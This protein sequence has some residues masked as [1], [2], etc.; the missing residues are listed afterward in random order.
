[1]LAEEK[2]H[3]HAPD[4]AVPRAGAGPVRPAADGVNNQ[5]FSGAADRRTGRRR[6]G[7][8]GPSGGNSWP[9]DQEFCAKGW[10][11][12]P[13]G[14]APSCR[15]TVTDKPELVA[16]R[17]DRGQRARAARAVDRRGREPPLSGG[18]GDGFTRWAMSGAVSE[19]ELTGRSGPDA[20]PASG[21]GKTGIEKVHDEKLR[22]IAGYQPGSRSMRSDGSSGSCRATMARRAR[23]SS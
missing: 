2:P 3:Q 23:T 1:M 19:R 7:D 9:I 17:Q 15:W 6:R 22:G 12:M 18:G 13:A 14:G 20:A 16:G 4:R 11:A 5:N 10:C 21:F 8:A